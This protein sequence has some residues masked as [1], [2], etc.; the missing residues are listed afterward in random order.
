MG[1]MLSQAIGTP[2]WDLAYDSTGGYEL[3]IYISGAVAMISLGVLRK[4]GSASQT[5]SSLLF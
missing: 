5:L 2:L 1:C 3:G 4:T